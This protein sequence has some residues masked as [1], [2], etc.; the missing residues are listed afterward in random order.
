MKCELCF[1]GSSF[2]P[3]GASALNGCVKRDDL[4]AAIAIQLG[5]HS[6]KRGVG[7]TEDR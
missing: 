7:V 4:L 3:V 5:V 6:A 1:V 2:G